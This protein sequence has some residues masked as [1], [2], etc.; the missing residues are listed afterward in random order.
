[1]KAKTFLTVL[2][3]I[4][5]IFPVSAQDN[6]EHIVSTNNDSIVG[7]TI[8]KKK[9]ILGTVIS[10]FSSKENKVDEKV[11]DL[12]R[13]QDKYDSLALRNDSLNKIIEGFDAVKQ[14]YADS[15]SEKRVAQAN[16]QNTRLIISL[17]Q[18]IDSI[19]EVY[20]NGVFNAMMNYVIFSR[21]DSLAIQSQYE[22]FDLLE[23]DK[24]I[25]GNK[26]KDKEHYYP[27]FKEYGGITRQI[28]LCI[29]MTITD[30][31]AQIERGKASDLFL[32]RIIER[33]GYTKNKTKNKYENKYGYQYLDEIIDEAMRL[34]EDPKKYNVKEFETLKDKLKPRKW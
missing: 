12:L 17:N 19:C 27:M 10:I 25:A 18:R 33:A 16:E 24:R 23:L 22:L 30:I 7:D 11:D 8:P 4:C 32:S 5:S 1:M 15:V 2:L 29:D 34:F 26:R 13:L 6:K 14:D 3:L 31:E 28:S 20:V 21:Y 9:G